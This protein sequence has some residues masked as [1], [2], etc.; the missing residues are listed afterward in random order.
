MDWGR[1]QKSNE[2]DI[3]AKLYKQI[4]SYSIPLNN[5]SL[6]NALNSNV[7]FQQIL[8]DHNSELSN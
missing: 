8:I 1:V 2:E 3:K 7:N 4:N 6:L 5:N